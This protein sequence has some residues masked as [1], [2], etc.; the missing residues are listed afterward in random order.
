MFGA[1]NFPVY[2]QLDQMDCGPTCL[3]I[4][5]DFYG[6]NYNLNYLREISCLQKGGVSLA[7]LSDALKRIGMDSIGIK[8]TVQELLH[9]VPL[10]AIAHWSNNHFL[11]VYRTDK[12]NVFVSD[13]ALGRM[14]Y[15]HAE[16][17][18]SWV[19][20]NNEGV[21]LLA[22]PNQNFSIQDL[23]DNKAQGLGFLIDYLKPYKKY[24]YQIFL[25]LFIASVVQ[26]ILPFLTQSIVDYG[27]NYENIDFI[28]LIVIAQ[29][30]LFLV[31][32]ASGI[33]RD[34]ILLHIGTKVIIAMISDYLDKILKLPIAFFD[35]KTTGDFMQRIYD[36]Q[37]IEEFLSGRS[38]TILFD[39]LTIFIFAIILGIFNTSIFMIFITGTILFMGWSLLF[40]KKKEVLDHQLFDLNRKDQSL[41]LQIILSVLEIKLNNSEERRK[42]E[43]RI[44]QTQLFGLQS[45]IL[46]VDQAQING[47]KFINEFTSILIIFWS[48]KAVIAGEISLGT[49]LAIQFIVGSLYVPISNSMDFLVGYQ[50]ARLSLDRLSEIHNQEPEVKNAYNGFYMDPGD[51]VFKNVSFKFNPISSRSILHNISI[52]IA[53]GKVTA[54]VGASGSGKTTLLKL[55]LKLYNPIEGK[56]SIG[57]QNLENIKADKWRQVCGAVLQDGILFNDTIE[58]NITESKSQ[59]PVNQNEIDKAVK[60]ANLSDFID[61]LPFK[62]QTKIGEQGQLLSG[63]EKQRLLIARAIYKNPDYLFFDEAT[64]SLDAENEKVITE[65]LNQFY[66]NKT[67]VII[68]HRLS[69][70]KNA[71]QILV[72]HKGNVVEEGN[73]QELLSRQGFYYQLIQNQL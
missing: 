64:S 48:A 38:L 35:S 71:D 5:T 1:N 33:I 13:P 44:N 15:S 51:I 23:E 70:V 24:I 26:L 66:K 18:N 40:M 55:L 52:T 72:M 36:H 9:E 53:Q 17:R 43:W 41:F 22:E 45:S 61:E 34:W 14:K 58:R 6:G 11:V 42:S 57:D 68:A 73:H 12:R 46:R 62:Y 56:I 47:G 37:R 28:S 2:R 21:L 10:P 50:R 54:I 30:F 20:E 16:F 4:I 63:G 59:E 8:A 19:E 69:T 67:V 60:L 25:G 31:R 49:M 3:K 65:N 7:G 27:I 32:S 39:L 29:L